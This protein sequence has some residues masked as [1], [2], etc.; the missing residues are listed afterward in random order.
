MG[1]SEVKTADG[2]VLMS[3][4]DDTVTA[5][6]LLEG[7]TATNSAGEKITGVLTLS[8]DNLL[9]NSD[10]RINQRGASSYTAAGYS[11]DCWKLSGALTVNDGGGIGVSFN[12]GTTFSSLIQTIERPYSD[13]SG[14]KVA[15]SINIGGT[16]YSST[17]TFGEIALADKI[18]I[19]GTYFSGGNI[20]LYKY[21]NGTNMQFR[22]LITAAQT[23]IRWVKLEFGEPT[24]Y[25]HPDTA[26]ELAKCQRYALALNQYV[27]YGASMVSVNYIDFL[28]P[29]P[30]TL[31]VSPTVDTSKLAIFQVGAT[32][33]DGFTF[34][35]L[36]KG[37]N[38]V[39]VRATKASHGLSW[40]YLSLTEGIVIS[41]DM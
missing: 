11:V 12:S 14:K 30:S 25:A 17:Y 33:A 27:R 37:N 38:G 18:D 16:V 34:S 20:D 31:R 4:V 10:F 1:V 19:G 2:E 41:A 23:D 6:A 32:A 40:A 7:Y 5:E 22:I 8:N 26:S 29:T 3:T 36:A 35:V 28:I 39:M 13:F 9:I 21:A 15:L 24:A